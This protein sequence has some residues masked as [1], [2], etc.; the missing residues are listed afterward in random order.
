M[1]S[2][3]AGQVRDDELGEE[4]TVLDGKPELFIA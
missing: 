4:Q 2:E 1:G 3:V